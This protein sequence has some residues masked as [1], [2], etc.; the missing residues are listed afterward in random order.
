MSRTLHMNAF[1]MST[2][3]HEASWR[4]PESD[5]RANTDI[6][7]Y[8]TLARIAE[9]GTFDSLFLADGPALW[10]DVGHRPGRRRSSR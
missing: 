5:P 7:H 9:R 1:L 8:K 3:H 2:G 4:L 10:G 6:E